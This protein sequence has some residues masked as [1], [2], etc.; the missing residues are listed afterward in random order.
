MGEYVLA[1]HREF[2]PR[3][4]HSHDENHSIKMISQP[5]LFY[6]LVSLP[7]FFFF[8]RR[9]SLYPAFPQIQNLPICK[10]LLELMPY[11]CPTFTIFSLVVSFKLT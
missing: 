5:E 3:I 2:N 9:K 10:S 1:K 11:P 8:C 6:V 7:A 4:G